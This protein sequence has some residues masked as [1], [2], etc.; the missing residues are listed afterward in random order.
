MRLLI[1]GKK[2]NSFTIIQMES[3][4][5]ISSGYWK[6]PQV[7]QKAED[8]LPNLIVRSEKCGGSIF[9]RTSILHDWLSGKLTSASGMLWWQTWWRLSCILPSSTA[10]PAL[11]LRSWSLLEANTHG[12]KS[13]KIR[14]HYGKAQNF[15][16]ELRETDSRKSTENWA[17]RV[18]VT[19]TRSSPS[20]AR[21]LERSWL[22]TG[23]GTYLLL[24]ENSGK[25]NSPVL[26]RD[27]RPFH[28][29][30][31]RITAGQNGATCR[32]QSATLISCK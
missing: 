19:E 18:P 5:S 26:S 22:E 12:I 13:V 32:V 7:Q 11:P 10:S 31:D 25:G 6:K 20:D 4:Q 8:L 28:V 3:Y 15:L 30:A 24:H 27:V 9:Q 1:L 2:L 16:A 21:L 17:S 29:K 14:H 23:N